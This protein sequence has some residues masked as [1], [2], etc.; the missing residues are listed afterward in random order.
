MGLLQES[1]DENEDIVLTKEERDLSNEM[2]REILRERVVA[3]VDL[4]TYV[5][6]RVDKDLYDKAKKRLYYESAKKKNPEALLQSGRRNYAKHK[7][8]RLAQSK[9]YYNNNREEI[10]AQKQGYYRT[11]QDKILAQRKENYIAH[12]REVLDTDLAEYRRNKSNRSYQNCKEEISAR[13]KAKRQATKELWK[14][15]QKKIF[16]IGTK[17][18]EL[19]VVKQKCM[20]YAA[21]GIGYRISQVIDPMSTPTSINKTGAT[22]PFKYV[23]EELDLEF[24][25]VTTACFVSLNTIRKNYQWFLLED[26]EEE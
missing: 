15:V 20:N 2:D 9:I 8:Q 24:D 13:R 16:T 17:Q 10:L 4:T 25:S 7:E 18:Y 12:P 26:E 3:G 19:Y 14:N 23:Y 1:W 5:H 11:N 6:K 22:F 21:T